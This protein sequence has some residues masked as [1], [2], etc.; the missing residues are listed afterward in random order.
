MGSVPVPPQQQQ[1][2]ALQPQALPAQQTQMQ[3]SAPYSHM[4]P[5]QVQQSAGYPNMQAPAATPMNCEQI[6]DPAFCKGPAM[7]SGYICSWQENECESVD[8]HE[9][10]EAPERPEAGEA[11]KQK[12]DLCEAFSLNQFACQSRPG[13]VFEDF[14]CKTAERAVI[15]HPFNANGGHGVFPNGAMPMGPAQPVQPLMPV[16]PMIPAQPVPPMSP[17]PV[18]AVPVPAGGALP[19]QPTQPANPEDRP[20]TAFTPQ[21]P[22][23]N[24]PQPIYPTPN[25]ASQQTLPAHPTRPAHP[26]PTQ[27]T[28][29]P[30]PQFCA[31]L[32]E[33]Q[34]FG[35]SMRQGELC[36]WD[37][38][39]YECV[40]AS[41]ADMEAIC[42]QFY[43][44]PVK[45]DEHENCF[46]DEVDKEC[47]ENK[48]T[49]KISDKPVLTQICSNFHDIMSCASQ[50]MCFWDTIANSNLGLCV[51]VIQAEN[52]CRVLDTAIHCSTNALC[53]WQGGYCQAAGLHGLLQAAPR[54]QK[55]A[56]AA[57]GPQDKAAP[58]TNWPLDLLV[59][60]GASVLGLTIGLFVSWAHAKYQTDQVSNE[61]Y[62]DIMMDMNQVRQI[63]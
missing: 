9:A 8:P 18:P 38:E 35:P 21:Q 32:P 60:V 55:Y 57:K 44:D 24:A 45:C 17:V 39:D 33:P 2:G 25:V 27:P 41:E 6:L 4:Q 50:A 22:I 31:S 42:N 62:R 30:G 58:T 20:G 14:E 28:K 5:I 63:V 47:A 54:L 52:V 34:C 7:Q 59:G 19:A 49:G 40:T 15:P 13:C 61:D 1:I 12:S 23:G 11:P 26:M 56:A 10:H 48:Y 36:M 29:Q 53:H 3:Q 51:N 43:R 37:A 46:W 16:P